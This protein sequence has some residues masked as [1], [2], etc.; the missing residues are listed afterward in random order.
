MKALLY[1]RTGGPD[2]LE[3][4]DIADPTPGPGD[5]V[6]RVHATAL[7]HLDLVQRNG[8]FHLV[9]FTLPHI[10]GMDIA[11]TIVEVG[12]EVDD[13]LIG[14][15]VVV[16]P[17]MTGVGEK[18]KL[19]GMGDVYGHLGVLGGN[20]DGGYAELCVAPATHVHR[21]PEQMHWHQAT[22]FPSAWMTAH[23]ALFDC[24]QL[25]AGETFMVHAAGSGVS[26][27]AIQLAKQAGAT[28]LATAGSDEKCQRAVELGADHVAN[29]RQTAIAEWAREVTGGVGVDLVF[30]HVGTALFGQ[31]LFAL[32]PRGRLVNCGN[33]SGDEAVIPSLGY[34]FKNGLQIIGSDPYRHHEFGEAWAK[35]CAGDFH[36]P[37]DAVY[38]LAEGGQA[39]AQLE[40]GDVFGKILLEP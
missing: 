35:Y 19:T 39:Q 27:A 20:L 38:P 12:A 9:G 1:R 18:S 21:I 22:A 29:N 2:V 28:V 13:G 31:S 30:D 40:R 4:T 7:N 26:T 14:A 5:V 32:K 3:Y 37:I 33:T 34:M 16:D 23:H 25:I 11:G 24:G 15:R 8:Y 6:V 36:S 17:S 10:S